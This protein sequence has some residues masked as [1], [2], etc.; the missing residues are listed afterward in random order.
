ML[1]VRQRR[2]RSIEPGATSN[3]S[4]TAFIYGHNS[5]GWRWSCRQPRELRLP[6]ATDRWTWKSSL[7]RTYRMRRSTTACICYCCCSRHS[8]T[9]CASYCWPKYR[10]RTRGRSR[11]TSTHLDY[12]ETLHITIN[13][14]LS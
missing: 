6:A 5:N 14:L 11:H 12:P 7:R 9:Y 8:C 4:A 13:K 2:G 1:S 10:T 3:I